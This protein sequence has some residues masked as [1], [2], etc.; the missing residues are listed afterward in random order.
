VPGRNKEFRIQAKLLH[1]GQ[2][3][4]VQAYSTHGHNAVIFTFHITI[5]SCENKGN[6]HIREGDH[7]PQSLKKWLE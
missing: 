3:D 5:A 1:R 2:P 6:R 7:M 4:A